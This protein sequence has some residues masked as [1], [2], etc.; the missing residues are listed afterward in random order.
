MTIVDKVK[1]IKEER[2][3]DLDAWQR[4]FISD[5]YDNAQ[6]DDELTARQ[7]SKV[8]EIWMDLGL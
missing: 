8:D 2:W 5:L 4:G 7:K 1:F 6:D 3:I